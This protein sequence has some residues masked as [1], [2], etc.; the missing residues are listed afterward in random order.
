[1]KP[2]IDKDKVQEYLDRQLFSNKCPLCG[3]PGMF[4]D[5][6]KVGALPDYAFQNVKLLLTLCCN[7]CG[8]TAFID[9]A[10]QGLIKREGG[11][12]AQ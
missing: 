11:C 6:G 1:M 2:T 10:Q 12:H 9:A 7:N 4:M 5:I 3:V 8:Y